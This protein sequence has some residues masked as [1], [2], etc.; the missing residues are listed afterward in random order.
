MSLPEREK[1]IFVRRYFYLC[2]I[3]EIAKS[4]ALGESTTAMTLSRT[5]EKLRRHLTKEGF[6]L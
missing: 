4:L 1:I 6:A 5:R 2:P 3:A